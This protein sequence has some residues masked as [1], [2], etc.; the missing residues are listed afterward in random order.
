MEDWEIKTIVLGYDGSEGSERAL[1]LAAALA[2][3]GQA[4][5]Y[6]VHAFEPPNLDPVSTF[7]GSSPPPTSRLDHAMASARDVGDKAVLE[8]TEAG[9]EA[10]PEMIQGSPGAAILDVA[11]AKAADLIVVGRRGHGFLKELL[12]GSTSEHVVRRAKA[13]VLIAH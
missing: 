7:G 11:E 2:R 5:V 13:P 12:L 10:E 6:V 9:I 8:L 4:T 3:P 1:R